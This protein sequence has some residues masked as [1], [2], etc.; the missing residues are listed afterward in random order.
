MWKIRKLDEQ[1]FMGAAAKIHEFLDIE[2]LM[3]PGKLSLSKQLGRPLMGKLINEA[4]YIEEVK[5]LDCEVHGYYVC[6]NGRR[7][8]YEGDARS[9][10]A[11]YGA[12][13][14]CC[15]WEN[16]NIKAFE[17][18]WRV[19]YGNL[20]PYTRDGPHPALQNLV[21]AHH[22]FDEAHSIHAR[23]PYSSD[24]DSDSSPRSRKKPRSPTFHRLIC[25]GRVP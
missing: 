20:W 14:R 5:T 9:A 10:P 15:G 11:I 22:A 12:T 7:S 6:T 16:H 1:L 3:S 2:S 8:S 4:V 13:V 23:R 25:N 18:G 17:M 21:S 24:S 19:K